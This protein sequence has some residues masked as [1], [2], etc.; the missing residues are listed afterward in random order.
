MNTSVKMILV[1]TIISTLSGGLLSYWDAYT[2]EKIDAYRQQ[3]IQQAV[4]EVLP[5]TDEE[6]VLEAGGF[7]FYVGYKDSDITGVAFV[8]EGGGFQDIISLMVGVTP[9]FSE[10][11]GLTVLSQ[12]ETPGL[13]T[14]IAY[15]PSREGSETWFIDQF[16]GKKTGNLTYVKNQKAS[17][18]SEIEAITGATISSNAVITILNKHVPTAK[19]A[20]ESINQ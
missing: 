18:D 20:F 14:K 15:D 9:D 7:T 6:K 10:F 8:A 17:G 3:E 5:D 1:L 19:S 12:K 4:K 11:T 13:G 16:Q 2:S